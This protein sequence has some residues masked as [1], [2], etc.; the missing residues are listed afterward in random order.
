M[1][2]SWASRAGLPA[3][4]LPLL[5][6][7]AALLSA[8]VLLG[9]RST[10]FEAWRLD[11][12]HSYPELVG[13]AKLLLAAVLLRRL[14]RQFGSAVLVAWI[15]VLFL[16]VADDAGRLHERGGRIL[17]GTD[18]L[19]AAFGLAPSDL[20]ELVVWTLMAVLFGVPLRV[21]HGRADETSR[22]LSVRL[23]GL[24]A[25]LGVFAVVA[26]AAHQLV[27]VAVNQVAVVVEDGGELIAQSILVAFLGTTAARAS[28]RAGHRPMFGMGARVGVPARQWPPLPPA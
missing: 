15:G 20:G 13:Y 14:Q 4:L 1:Q 5:G 28:R 6:L 11:T 22:W 12:D 25:V 24:V 10:L 18:S 23:A 17:A 2:K 26:D 16:V 3:V 19:P 7:D 9:E 8:H 27:P 21:L